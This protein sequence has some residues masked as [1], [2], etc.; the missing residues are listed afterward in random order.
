M[1][2]GGVF[3]TALD[4]ED[5]G[6]GSGQRASGGEAE[7][8]RERLQELFETRVKNLSD[9]EKWALYTNI[10]NAQVK[11]RE[12]REVARERARERADKRR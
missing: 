8:V 3:G 12:E 1:Q 6:A 10:T 5:T 7:D 4:G 2:T 9:E 11:R